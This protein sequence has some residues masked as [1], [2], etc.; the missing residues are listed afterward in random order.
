MPLPPD[1]L[2]RVLDVHSVTYKSKA[3]KEEGV[4]STV[5]VES[6]FIMYL[7]IVE[8]IVLPSWW[9][10]NKRFLTLHSANHW[11]RYVLE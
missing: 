5:N 10:D 8:S 7:E 9:T 11:V 4:S 3:S 2:L 1:V 6:L